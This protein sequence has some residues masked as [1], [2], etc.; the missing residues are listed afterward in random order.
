[1]HFNLFWSFASLPNLER[2][3]EKK[4]RKTENPEINI[5]VIQGEE[6]LMYNCSL[7]CVINGQ[8]HVQFMYIYNAGEEIYTRKH[9]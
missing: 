8:A 7:L 6:K 1:M 5:Q 9:F 3:R 2:E 4:K